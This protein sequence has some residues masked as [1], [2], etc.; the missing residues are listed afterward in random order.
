MISAL[1]MIYALRMKVRTDIIFIFADF[2]AQNPPPRL[3]K[4][5]IKTDA[6]AEER[7][8]PPGKSLALAFVRSL[9]ALF[10]L[11]V[12]RTNKKRTFVYQDNGAFFE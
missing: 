6:F 9:R 2:R 4:P 11:P 8:L 1:Q 3:L 12:V 10:N 7:D 5:Q